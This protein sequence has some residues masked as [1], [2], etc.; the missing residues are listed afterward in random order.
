MQHPKQIGTVHVETLDGELCIYDWQRKQV[1]NLNPTAARVWELCD[2][3]TTPQ[4]MAAQLHGDLTPAQAEELVWLSLKRLEGAYLLENKVVQPAGRNV[5]TRREMLKGLGVAAMMLPVVTSI[6]A[7]GPAAAQSDGGD[8]QPGGS[9]V[10]TANVT[11]ITGRS[12]G[13]FVPFNAPITDAQIAA[14][15]PT[16]ITFSWTSGVAVPTP[17]DA[18]S[19]TIALYQG[20][21]HQPA[22]A[23]HTFGPG[24][25]S[26]QGPFGNANLW[27][28]NRPYNGIQLQTDP[29]DVG[30]LTVTLS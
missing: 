24:D 18:F 25:T 29:W 19:T 11:T 13:L 8:N 22:L 15:S 9:I 20:Y 2:G 21:G 10:R 5:L 17:G 7:P 14:C 27:T 3:R 4:E 6:V 26:P 28:G 23:T 30:T 1:H 16:G 12:I